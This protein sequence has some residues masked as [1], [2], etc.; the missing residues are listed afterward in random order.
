MA[1]R[2][3]TQFNVRSDVF[4]SITPPPWVQDNIVAP[5][6]TWK[7]A[8]WLPV[9]FVKSN[10]DVGTRGDAFVIS[11]GKV[12]ALDRQGFVVPAGLRGA[13]NKTT[14]TTV[15]TY[16]ATDYDW[17]V[18]DLTTGQRYAVNGTTSYTAL[19]VAKALVERGL[20]P[21]NVISANPPSSNSDVSDVVE[22]FIGLP[23]GVIAY[24]VYK[25]GGLAEDGD[26][27]YTNYNKQ[28]AV[29]FY[30]EWQ[31]KVPWRV[32]SD[33]TSDTFDVS[34]ITVTS[35]VSGA[36]DFPQPG[37]VWDIDAIVDLARYDL[38]GTE[39]IVALALANKPVAKN[40]D[41]TPFSSDVSGMLSKEKSTITAVKIEGDWYLDAEVGLLF[42]HEDTYATLV[43]D[44]SD[45]TLS[46]S[47]Y[48]DAG[49]GAA[50]EQ[51]IYFDGEG[52]PGDL[53]SVDEK[54]NFVVKGVS[55][56]ILASTDPHLG[57]LYYTWSE[58]RQLLDKVKSAF[59]LSNMNAAGKMPG[60]AT[61]GYSDMITLASEAVADRI[62]VLAV[63][64]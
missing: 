9:V 41:R 43:S 34:A 14:G 55:D 46:Y 29:Q 53:L 48:D 6:G 21:E 1:T 64:I 52:K 39:P 16:T 44:N 28:H 49:I 15:L 40:T 5:H 61:K 30:T 60:T 12:V 32:A 45:P 57:R 37:E 38:A 7:P 33:T 20:V 24:D 18:I 54:S 22:A 62:A 47:Y 17:G 2:I 3:S 36:G 51:W 11:C 19:Q 31:M 56:D 23:V 4:S 42:V 35:A 63:R 13:L 10:R 25:Y 8:P 50:S 26:Q 59:S 27:F 58:P